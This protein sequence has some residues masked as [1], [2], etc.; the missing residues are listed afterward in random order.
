MAGRADPARVVGCERSGCSV[1]LPRV[2]A[3]GQATALVPLQD[4]EEEKKEGGSSGLPFPKDPP[5]FLQLCCS[6]GR[7]SRGRGQPH[8]KAAQRKPLHLVLH[9]CTG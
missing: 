4:E 8:S 3:T 9:E 5:N 7:W 6:T 1:L 2:Q